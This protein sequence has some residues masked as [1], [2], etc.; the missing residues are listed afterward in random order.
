MNKIKELHSKT[1]D[2]SLL[3]AKTEAII[4]RKPPSLMFEMECLDD[5]NKEKQFKK[6]KAQVKEKLTEWCT[7]FGG[8]WYLWDKN[9]ALT[10]IGAHVDVTATGDYT[11]DI[12]QSI[13]ILDS[14]NQSSFPIFEAPSSLMKVLSDY[15]SY[16]LRIY[17]ILPDDGEK[18][19]I[20]RNIQK[21]LELLS[22]C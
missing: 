8:E 7:K 13:R 4:Y 16:S 10:K 19:K 12:E 20:R 15:A 3:K 17:A 6:Q 5:R 2:K 9:T 21:E 1:E 18:E 14:T 11:E 22:P